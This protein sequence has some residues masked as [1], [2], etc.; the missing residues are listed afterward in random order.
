MVHH[1][2]WVVPN[3]L[4]VIGL[5]SLYSLSDYFHNCKCLQLLH[6]YS[7]DIYYINGNKFSFHKSF[8]RSCY[9][10]KC[11]LSLSL[12]LPPSLSVPHTY[13]VPS[14]H[15][16]YVPYH[17]RL[18]KRHSKPCYAYSVIICIVCVCVCARA[19]THG[20]PIFHNY[21][22]VLEYVIRCKGLQQRTI[23]FTLTT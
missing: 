8:V 9:Q 7:W 6:S 13:F 15:N 12:P 5:V 4:C 18:I 23:L 21:I 22:F 3:C 16:Y 11:C 19:H 1:V 10:E 17:K 20:S 14:C 2:I